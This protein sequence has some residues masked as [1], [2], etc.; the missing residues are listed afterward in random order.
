MYIYACV[1][2]QALLLLRTAVSVVEY[3]CAGA[4]GGTRA[5]DLPEVEGDVLKDLASNLPPVRWLHRTR[6]EFEEN[7][8][9]PERI[10]VLLSTSIRSQQRR[11]EPPI[12]VVLESD[13]HGELNLLLKGYSG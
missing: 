6:S 2:Q 13:L 1:L 11:L 7:L 9:V 3:S 12:P 10:G 8:R 4:G 5:V